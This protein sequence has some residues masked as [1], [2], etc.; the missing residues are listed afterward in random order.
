MCLV[1]L[2]QILFLDLVV[3]TLFYIYCHIH[4]DTLRIPLLGIINVFLKII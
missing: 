3:Y 4:K 2:S 1:L